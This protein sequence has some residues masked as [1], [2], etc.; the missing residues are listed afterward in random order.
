[1]AII[2]VDVDDPTIIE[3]SSDGIEA[4]LCPIFRLLYEALGACGNRFHSI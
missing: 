3:F 2:A 1:V 4:W